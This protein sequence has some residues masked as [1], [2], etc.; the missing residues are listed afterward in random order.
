LRDVWKLVSSANTL[1]HLGKDDVK[2]CLLI[3]GYEIQNK[4]NRL[5]EAFAISRYLDDRKCNF[6]SFYQLKDKIISQ[7]INN[8]THFDSED[9][10]E[11]IESYYKLLKVYQSKTE[12]SLDVSRFPSVFD[13]HF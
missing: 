10:K 7:F 3:Q 13:T 5:D 1:R 4:K 6:G 11:I 2:L 9:S 12:S 8:P